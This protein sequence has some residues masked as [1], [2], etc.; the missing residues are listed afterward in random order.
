[1]R[2]EAYLFP[3][4]PYPVPRKDAAHLPYVVR[5]PSSCVGK[6]RTK[7]I[8]EQA[9]T[10]SP[11]TNNG[12][13]VLTQGNGQFPET[14][15]LTIK[16]GAFYINPAEMCFLCA[17]GQPIISDLQT[18][19]WFKKSLPEPLKGWQGLNPRIALAYLCDAVRIRT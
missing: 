15:L 11:A 10:G 9:F 14:D 8:E 18:C 13:H 12:N 17:G 16:D 7:C 2:V 1:V 4:S 19:L 3:R 6:P 5:F